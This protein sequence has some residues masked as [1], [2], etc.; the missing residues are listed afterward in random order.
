MTVLA[1]GIIE[2]TQRW[3]TRPLATLWAG[4]W[5]MGALMEQDVRRASP[6]A[7]RA[8]QGEGGASTAAMARVCFEILKLSPLFHTKFD[9][10]N[11]IGGIDG[12]VGRLVGLDEGDRSPVARPGEPGG[13][14]RLD[15]P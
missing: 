12:M 4:P 1:C 8:S 10:I 9:G 13:P 15:G 6:D 3:H 7:R 14:Q 2:G 5:H 11:G